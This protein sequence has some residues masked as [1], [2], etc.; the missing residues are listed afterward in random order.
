[1][2]TKC[3]CSLSPNYEIFKMFLI[4]VM[5]LG[6]MHFVSERISKEAIIL[7]ENSTDPDLTTVLKDSDLIWVNNELKAS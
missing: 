7:L 3:L 6:Q 5:K 1:M 2:E 4:P